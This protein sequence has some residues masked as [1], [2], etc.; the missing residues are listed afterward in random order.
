MPIAVSHT[1][2]RISKIRRVFFSR[3]RKWHFYAECT[4]SKTM[5]SLPPFFCIQF[6]ENVPRCWKWISNNLS[7][8]VVKRKYMFARSFKLHW[9]PAHIQAGKQKTKK[10]RTVAVQLSLIP[11]TPSCSSKCSI[12]SERDQFLT[13]LTS[14]I[15]IAVNDYSLG[16]P[17][18]M[19]GIRNTRKRTK[20][21]WK[22]RVDISCG[23]VAASSGSLKIIIPP[24]H[25]SLYMGLSPKITLRV[26]L[27]FHFSDRSFTVLIV[28]S[29]I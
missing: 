4:S 14:T 15:L 5:Q 27:A 25:I 2:V 12:F 16:P 26:S 28:S 17:P 22:L 10:P 8:R 6:Y 11:I 7:E 23:K 1:S 29:T 24:S 18:M 9:N 19:G 13:F 21:G 20:K 3:C